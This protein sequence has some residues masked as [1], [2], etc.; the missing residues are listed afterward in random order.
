MINLDNTF[1]TS[2]HHFREWTRGNGFFCES[3]REDEEKHIALWNSVV[4]KDDTVLYVGDF[5][6]GKIA[7]LV[8]VCRRLNGKITFI[9]GNHDELDRGENCDGIYDMVFAKV[10]ERMYIDELN[11]LLIHDPVQL[12]HDPVKAARCPGNRIIY[13]HFHRGMSEPLPTTRDSVCVCAKWHDWRPISLAE[14]IRLM[15][16]ADA[17]TTFATMYDQRLRQFL[18]DD[19][20]KTTDGNR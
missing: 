11:L 12:L 5:T 13:G 7:D 9:R 10:V 17:S 20:P 4:G 15:D 18:E 2:D 1:V 14:A 3:T 8:Y 16:A 19:V 6:D